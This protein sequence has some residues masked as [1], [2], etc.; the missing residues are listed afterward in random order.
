MLQNTNTKIK[1][2]AMTAT[3]AERFIQGHL[4]DGYTVVVPEQNP[5][6]IGE[7]VYFRVQ[8]TDAKTGETR[9]VH[10]ST[11]QTDEGA[12]LK[13]RDIGFSA[14]PFKPVIRIR[15]TAVL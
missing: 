10:V 1:T 12:Q 14:S 9:G 8:L 4:V 7:D 15:E 2:I 13:V 6:M 3:E 11:T 5:L